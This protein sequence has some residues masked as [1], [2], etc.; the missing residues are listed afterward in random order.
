MCIFWQIADMFF[1]L[2]NVFTFKK[3]PAA[4]YLLIDREFVFCCFVL[5]LWLRYVVLFEQT[6]LCAHEQYHK[7]VVYSNE[8]QP[9]STYLKPFGFF[10]E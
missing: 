2:H 8:P 6:S 9:A 7:A 3:I 10:H 4:W 1:C 5:F